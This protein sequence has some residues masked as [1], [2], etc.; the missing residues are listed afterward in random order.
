ML[1]FWMA[2]P[3]RSSGRTPSRSVSAL[4]PD[5]SAK[6]KP[7]SMEAGGVVTI[8]VCVAGAVV[9]G[10]VVGVLPPQAATASAAAAN[11]APWARVG[12]DMVGVSW[13]DARIGAGS[14]GWYVLFV[15]TGS[16]SRAHAAQ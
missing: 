15:R 5:G 1:S 7:G 12:R 9:A 14:P 2:T 13:R 16:G 11:A 6:L 3:P 8:G 10:A 4:K